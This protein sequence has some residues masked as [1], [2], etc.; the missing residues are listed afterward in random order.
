MNFGKHSQTLL[1]I[2][3]N[4][5]P[6]HTVRALQQETAAKRGPLIDSVTCIEFEG[7]GWIFYV[8]SA[9]AGSASACGHPELGRVID[10][11]NEHGFN[12]LKLEEEAEPVDGLPTFGW[13]YADI[14]IKAP[15]QPA[16]PSLADYF[17]TPRAYTP[18]APVLRLEL[19]AMPSDDEVA[20][21][22]DDATLLIELMAYGYKPEPG[23]LLEFVRAEVARLGF[24]PDGRGHIDSNE[25]GV[26]SWSYRLVFI[27]RLD[28]QPA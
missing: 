4:H 17:D 19:L 27:D 24:A 10:F 3:I 8:C 28:H 15:A 21:A 1:N 9:Q 16:A 26:A 22:D 25:H 14:E 11:A 12:W 6:A 13:D 20:H 7:A 2:S 18:P 23:V 5:I